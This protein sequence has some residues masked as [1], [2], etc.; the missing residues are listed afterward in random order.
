MA[1]DRGRHP[2]CRSGSSAA[3]VTGSRPGVPRGRARPGPRCR[4]SSSHSARSPD[5][6]STGPHREEYL[7]SLYQPIGPGLCARV[8]DETRTDVAQDGG[9]VT[10]VLAA[11][12]IGGVAWFDVMLLC[13]ALVILAAAWIVMAAGTGRLEVSSA[14]EAASAHRARSRAIDDVGGD[15]FNG[16]TVTPRRSGDGSRQP[17]A[18]SAAS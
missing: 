8:D 4:C 11:P 17:S 18:A 2:R 7:A 6:R 9:P 1:H 5:P 13:T 16:E 14:D 3:G 12:M 10:T 15:G